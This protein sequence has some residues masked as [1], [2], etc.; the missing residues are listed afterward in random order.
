MLV[1]C[2]QKCL[3]WKSERKLSCLASGRTNDNFKTV[4]PSEKKISEK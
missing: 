1:L 2:V 4:F 3:A